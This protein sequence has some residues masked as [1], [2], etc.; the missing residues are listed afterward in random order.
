MDTPKDV[1][2]SGNQA[3]GNQPKNFEAMAHEILDM[4]TSD[5]FE[6]IADK[7]LA[8]NNGFEGS[9]VHNE[10]MMESVSVVGKSVCSKAATI[11]VGAVGEPVDIKEVA[12][13]AIIPP[14]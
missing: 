11:C 8:E 7:V 1:V 12:P 13:A 4:V 10:L 6:E 2:Q 3:S 9:V 5:L 14:I